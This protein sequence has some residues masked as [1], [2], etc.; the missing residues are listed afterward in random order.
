MM[1]PGRAQWPTVAAQGA[2][3]LAF[4]HR[5]G[6]CAL[7]VAHDSNVRPLTTACPCVIGTP[8]RSTTSSQRWPH[9][10]PRLR[11]PR[12]SWE[13]T[14]PNRWGHT[15]IYRTAPPRINPRTPPHT[16][17]PACH[18]PAPTH[19]LLQVHLL[20]AL[21]EPAFTTRHCCPATAHA[22]SSCRCWVCCLAPWRARRSAVTWWPSAWA[23][24]RCCTPARCCPRCWSAP[25]PPRPTCAQW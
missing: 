6:A 19:A 10:T 11:P 15:Q 16:T 9:P 14:W 20:R 4:S 18:A 17:P 2:P 24:W 23:A 1:A 3:P 25:P 7:R 13:R 22:T 8:R 5:T 21:H 12:Q